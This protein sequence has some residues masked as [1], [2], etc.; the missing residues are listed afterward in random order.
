MRH[1]AISRPSFIL[2]AMR[3][4]SEEQQIVDSDG[5]HLLTPPMH[6]HVEHL[7]VHYDPA[8]WGSDAEEF[9]PSRW[10]DSSGQL[11]TL[12]QKARTCPGLLGHDMK[13]SQV[14]FVATIATLFQRAR[15]EPLPIAG[16][17]DPDELQQMLRQKLNESIIKMTL[18]VK[19][20]QEVALRWIRDEA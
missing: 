2:C 5:S 3:H 15:C 6:I 17:E 9:K 8:I 18:Q 10:I 13:M 16:I 7:N 4:I 19:D 12:R 11:I 20:P 1:C 14:E